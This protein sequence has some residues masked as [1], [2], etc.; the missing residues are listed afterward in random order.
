MQKHI[1]A[2]LAITTLAAAA[3]AD[4]AVGPYVGI[5]VGASRFDFDAISSPRTAS[6][7]SSPAQKLFVG[8][9]FTEHWGAEV[10]YA[11]LGHIRNTY[12]AGNFKGR[13][14]AFYLA[15]T[16]RLPVSDRFALTA[17]V[18]LAYGRTDASSASS[19]IPEFADLRRSSRSVTLGS[20][21]AEYAFTPQT[22]ASIELDNIGAVSKK[23]DAAMLSVNLKYHF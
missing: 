23:S 12:A 9:R 8:Y 3:R 19:S 4:V 1:L 5:G 17:K 2:A 15:G 10:G 11:N 6:D 22:T 7:R 16:G 14:E 13:A 20:V 21:G 18:M